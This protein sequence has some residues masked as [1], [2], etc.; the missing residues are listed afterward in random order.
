[1][2]KLLI[3]WHRRRAV[4]H[5][6]RAAVGGSIGRASAHHAVMEDWHLEQISRLSKRAEQI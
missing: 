4:F 1:M 3:W 6:A 5:K 2:T